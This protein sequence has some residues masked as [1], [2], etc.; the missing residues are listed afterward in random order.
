M[1]TH[2]VTNSSNQERYNTNNIWENLSHS[3]SVCPRQEVGLWPAKTETSKKQSQA[4][5]S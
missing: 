1:Q 4:V 5:S 2:T 3:C